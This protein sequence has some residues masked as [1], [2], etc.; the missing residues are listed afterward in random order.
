LLVG[1]EGIGSFLNNFIIT[2]RIRLTQTNY[3]QYMPL[4]LRLRHPRTRKN[5]SNSFSQSYTW[6]LRKLRF[7][8]GIT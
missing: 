5:C 8:Q 7:E 6:I 1:I 2:L 4:F 3:L